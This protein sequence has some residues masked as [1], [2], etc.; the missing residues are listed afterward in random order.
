MAPR[1]AFLGDIVIARRVAQHQAREAGHSKN[2]ELRLLALHGLLH[3]SSDTTTN[4]T[5]ERCVDSS[6]ACGGRVGCARV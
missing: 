2:T 3:L 4:G 1:S 5:T 6:S